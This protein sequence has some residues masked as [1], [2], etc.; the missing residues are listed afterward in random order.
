LLIGFCFGAA[1][2]SCRD[3]PDLLSALEVNDEEESGHAREAQGDEAI[4]CCWIVDGQEVGVEKDRAGLLEGY[5]MLLEI[6]AGLVLVPLEVAKA[7][8]SHFASLR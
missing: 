5:A 4:G 8:R 1:G 2:S 7:I 3:D 6:R